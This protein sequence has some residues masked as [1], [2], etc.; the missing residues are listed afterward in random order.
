MARGRQ[1]PE[2]VITRLREAGVAGVTGTDV[3]PLAQGDAAAS[4]SP[5]PGGRGRLEGRETRGRQGA[6]A[7]VVVANQ[8]LR[9][10]AEGAFR[11]RR[12]RWGLSRRPL[13]A[14]R[15]V[16]GPNLSTPAQ[17]SGIPHQERDS[18]RP[19][20]R[21]QHDP[22]STRV[23]RSHCSRCWLAHEWRTETGCGIPLIPTNET[24]SKRRRS[25]CTDGAVR[26]RPGRI[27]LGQPPCPTPFRAPRTGGAVDRDPNLSRTRDLRL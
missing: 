4:G 5:G 20:A 21:R 19:C 2:Q 15:C 16:L 11:A 9:E 18:T 6:V 1:T 8:I 7:D 27:T 24:T 26:R 23:H 14:V 13:R 22:Q 17:L 3:R 25:A 10:A 12:P